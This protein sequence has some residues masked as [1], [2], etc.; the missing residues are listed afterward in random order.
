MDRKQRIYINVVNFAWGTF[1]IGVPQG[2]DLGSLLFVIYSNDIDNE[3][4]GI[5][6]NNRFADD[7]KFGRVKNLEAKSP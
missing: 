7:N 4:S 2:S 5:I 1:F 3:N 6:E